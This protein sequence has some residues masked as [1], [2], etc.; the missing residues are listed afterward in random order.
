[1]AAGGGRPLSPHR[2]ER[3]G[4]VRSV[5]YRLYPTARQ[6]AALEDLLEV[7]RQLYNAALEER[8]GAWRWER[9]A[10]TRYDQYNG[11][12]GAAEWCP[13]LARFGEPVRDL[14]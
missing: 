9:R 5:T 12:T 1:M 2:G 14:V 10:V 8:R 3:A 7:Q 13:P 4:V 6:E 11:L